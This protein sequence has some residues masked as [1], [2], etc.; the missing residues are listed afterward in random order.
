[1]TEEQ[2]THTGSQIIVGVPALT[3]LVFGVLG[4]II[5][6]FLNVVI[7]RVP[8]GDSIVSPPSACPSCG[9]QLRPR[10]NIP[11]ISWLVLRGRCAHCGAPIS[12]RYPIVEAV[13]AVL[14]VA[15]AIRFDA[16][17]TAAFAS[18]AVAVL[19]PL[20]VIDLEHKRLPNV[21]VLPSIGVAAAWVAIDAIRTSDAHLLVESLLCGAAAFALFF[22]IALV[23]GGM[24]FGDVKLAGFI[25]IVAGRFG[26]EVAVAAVMGSFFT[27][28]IIAIGL[29]AARRV[30]RKSGIPFGPSMV[31]GTLIALFAGPS[32][33]R[34]W[35]G[36]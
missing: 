19:I 20:F 29:L 2:T 14:F 6:S 21:I 33:V 25:G 23:S 35:L 12:P 22:V 4:A 18:F 31:I 36:L 27:G 24:G 17:A 7:Y 8:R 9:A 1:M 13:T 3:A 32:P 15:C 26:W 10:E 16:I 30:G 28:G 11:M 5:G 34:A